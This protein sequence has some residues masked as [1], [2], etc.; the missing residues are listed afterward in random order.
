MDADV[1]PES[2]LNTAIANLYLAFADA[3][4]PRRIDSCPCCSEEFEFR[5]ICERELSELTVED[6]SRFAG[7]AMTTAGDEAD[8]LYV[9]PR[10][11]ELTAENSLLID[12]EVTG[13]RIA[14]TTPDAWPERRQVALDDYWQALLRDSIVHR[15]M[16]DDL[17]C[18][19]GLC[20][21]YIEP[22]L[23]LLE[24]DVELLG[25]Y[26]DFDGGK[27]TKTGRLSNAFWPDQSATH[28]RIV[29]W[30]QEPT[31]QAIISEY[32]ATQANSDI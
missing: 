30:F 3:R 10:V 15:A 22:Y 21:T 14:M 17:I 1:E 8:Y 24:Q 6:L 31:T 2:D 16:V 5:N 18:A 28:D 23:A 32:N 13:S 9:L 25:W 19:I 11:L 7:K 27:L 4:K 20:R 29:A 12:T 26:H